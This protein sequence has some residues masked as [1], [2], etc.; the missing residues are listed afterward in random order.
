MLWKTA[1]QRKTWSVPVKCFLNIILVAK[2]VYCQ[3]CSV[4][5]GACRN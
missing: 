3:V 5:F 2:T 4:N 1:K